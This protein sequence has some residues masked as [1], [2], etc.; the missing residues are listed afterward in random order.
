[1]VEDCAELIDELKMSGIIPA[2]APALG[3]ILAVD[4]TDIPAYARHRGEHCDPPGKENCKIKNHRHCDSPVPEECTR[5]SHQPCPDPD[6][7][8]GYR[9]PKSKEDKDKFFGYD[10]DVISDAYY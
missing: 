10:A 7:A 8:W 5:P 1:M 2:D 9:T 6:A 3:E 4:A